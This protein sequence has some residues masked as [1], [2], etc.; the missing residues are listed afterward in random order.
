MLA[1]DISGLM[2]HKPFILCGK[3]GLKTLG[4]IFKKATCVISNDSGPMH[5]AAAARAGVIAVFGPTSP[6][7]TGPYG[8]GRYIVLHKD[9]GCKIPCYDTKCE[10]NRCMKA[11]TVEDVMEAVMEMA[12]EKGEIR[13]NGGE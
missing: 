7:L 1:K 11:V 9:I 13:D 6:E 3:T 5:I 2:K 12:N 4:A 8:D 10:D